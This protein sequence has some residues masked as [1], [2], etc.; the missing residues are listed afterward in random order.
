[1]RTIKTLMLS[2]CLAALTAPAFAQGYKFPGGTGTANDPYQIKTAE[3]LNHVRDYMA[4]TTVCFKLMNDIDL[5]EYLGDEGSWE[6]IGTG[7]SNAFEGT[8]DGGNHVI[9]NMQI[10]NSNDSKGLFGRVQHPGVVKNLTM[11]NAYVEAARWSGILCSTNGNWEKQGGDLI[12][13]HVLNSYIEGTEEVAA[14]AGCNSGNII[15]CSSIGTEINAGNSVG[16]IAGNSSYITS[17][18]KISGC[19]S[20][21]IVKASGDIAG[22]IAGIFGAGNNTSNVVIENCVAYGEVSSANV[23]GGIAAYNQGDNARRATSIINCYSACNVSGISVGGIGG[24][25]IDGKAIGCYASGNVLV[26][27]N[28]DGNWSG[29]IIG[30]AYQSIEGCYFSG[31]ISKDA[32]VTK[33]KLGG[34]CGRNWPALVVKNCFYDKEG[35]SMNMGEGDDE[36]GFD[37][38]GLTRDQMKSFK[39]MTFTDAARWQIQEG[40]TLPY[41]SNQT[42]PVTIDRMDVLGAS[43][44]YTGNVSEIEFGSAKFLAVK[45]YTL[46]V[47]NGKWSVTWSTDP[48]E[49]MAENDV[50]TVFAKEDGKMP[51]MAVTAR[52]KK[53]DDQAVKGVEATSAS[54]V[55]SEGQIKATFASSDVASYTLS[56]VAGATLLSGKVA[57][58]VS[59]NTS[60][61][62]KGLYLFTV[63]Q[64][65]STNTYKVLVK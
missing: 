20:Y 33:A 44:T 53:A 17:N 58:S 30:T 15:D 61:F 27:G 50:I 1:M 23:A 54:V 39:T 51:S 41:F 64:N 60:S 8:F 6:P 4:N 48:S 43:G 9:Y 35:A 57:G 55:V 21:S 63:S 2:C 56:N 40:K 65:G 10:L 59:I 26:T 42:A 46:K 14:I 16:A 38:K 62:A 3:D 32:S 19:Y 37:A 52:V 12:N 24:S 7:T 22:G 34:V 11:D 5:A 36:K 45:N 47:E 25:P 28:S 31:T 49:G 13:C 29:G 18:M